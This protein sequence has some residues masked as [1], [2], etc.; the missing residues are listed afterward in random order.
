LSQ[1]NTSLQQANHQQEE[2]SP[3]PY[4]QNDNLSDGGLSAGGDSGATAKSG[5]GGRDKNY[6]DEVI[7]ITPEMYGITETEEPDDNDESFGPVPQHFLME[8]RV[9]FCIN[10]IPSIYNLRQY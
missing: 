3:L 7:E 1:F 9:C 10:F 5:G 4:E 6:Q 2:G 8:G